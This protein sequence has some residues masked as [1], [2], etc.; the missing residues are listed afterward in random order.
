[1]QALS[2]ANDATCAGGH[3]EVVKVFEIH[4]SVP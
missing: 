4:L 1:M 3:P 2:G